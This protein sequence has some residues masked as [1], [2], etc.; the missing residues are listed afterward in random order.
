MSADGRSTTTAGRLTARPAGATA[1]S[2]RTSSRPRTTPAAP[3]NGTAPVIPCASP[4]TV[5]SALGLAVTEA[6][7]NVVLHAYADRDTPGELELRACVV[8]AVL[9]VEVADQGRGMVPRI[10]SAGLGARPAVDGRDVGR[11]RD[12]HPP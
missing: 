4:K 9:V 7:A 8:D 1:T 6:C 3:P 5:R 2:C 10:E 11:L 12:P